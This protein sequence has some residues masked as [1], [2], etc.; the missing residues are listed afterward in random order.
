MEQHHVVTC[1][2]MHRGRIMLVRRGR[3]V[4]TYRGKWAG[5]S[6]YLERP[7]LEQAF[8]EIREETGLSQD[9]VRL[10][11]EGAVVE[12]VD[13]EAD[14][15]WM[16]HPFLFDVPE[17]EKIVL[18]WENVEYRWIL[19]QEIVDFETVPKLDEAL[20]QVLETGA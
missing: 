12:A 17:P 3:N 8:Q 11:R 2:L 13:D 9:D 6:G 15:Q 5:I 1:F 18:D 16:V 20:E 4:G 14:K 7:P 10:V 19:P